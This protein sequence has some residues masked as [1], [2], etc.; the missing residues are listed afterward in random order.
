MINNRRLKSD[1]YLNPSSYTRGRNYDFD[2]K[3]KNC[4]I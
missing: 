2:L 4:E 1:E 3:E